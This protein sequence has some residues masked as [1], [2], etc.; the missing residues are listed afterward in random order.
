MNDCIDNMPYPATHSWF[1]KSIGIPLAVNDWHV[2]A[3][4]LLSDQDQSYAMCLMIRALL[5]QLKL[6]VGLQS[7]NPNGMGPGSAILSG[8]SLSWET[9]SKIARSAGQFPGVGV[10]HGVG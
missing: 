6:L 9:T 10:L 5:L 2:G 8:L 7:N 3:C 1:S 4:K